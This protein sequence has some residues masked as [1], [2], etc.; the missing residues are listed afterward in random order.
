[1]VFDRANERVFCCLLLLHYEV[2]TN[3]TFELGSQSFCELAEELMRQQQRKAWHV[4][5]R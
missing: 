3:A 2:D 5:G 1:M 4:S